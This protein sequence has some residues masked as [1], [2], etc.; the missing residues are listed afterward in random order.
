VRR[1]F[2]MEAALLSLFSAIAGTILAL[3]SMKGLSLLSFPIEDNPLSMLLVRGHL[4]FVPRPG[5]T[6]V[7][8]LLVMGMALLAAWNPASQAAKLSPAN[9][10][11][12]HE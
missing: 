9:A 8:I 7:H 12:H 11:R 3:V 10:L 5:V 2:L 6:V 1:L 4:V